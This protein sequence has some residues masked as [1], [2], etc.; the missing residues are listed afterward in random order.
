VVS[1][2]TTTAVA[3]SPQVVI[4]RALLL[5]SFLL[6]CARDIVEVQGYRE[7][8]RVD[9]GVLRAFLFCRRYKHGVRSLESVVR[10]S[11]LAGKAS[12][13]RSCLP[14]ESQMELHV[15]LQEFMDLICQDESVL[16]D[17]LH[18]HGSDF[19]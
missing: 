8:L 4:R 3:Y 6:A 11:F 15:G 5:R 18:W 2:T 14:A 19:A 7:L 1:I 16:R 9:P 13:Q 12:F 10:M 17:Q